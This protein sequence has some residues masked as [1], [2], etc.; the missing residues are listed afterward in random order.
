MKLS[1]ITPCVHDQQIVHAGLN[2][3]YLRFERDHVL[4]K[5]DQ[6]LRAGLPG[7]TTI[8]IRPAGEE[9]RAALAPSLGDVVAQKDDSVFTGL[10][11]LDLGVLTAIVDEPA[12]I[13]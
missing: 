7:D 6:H 3:H 12:E 11:G 9:L 10:R 5:A 4:M 8:Q 2:D 1:A 13:L